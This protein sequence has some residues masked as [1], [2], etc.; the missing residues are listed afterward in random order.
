MIIFH[1]NIS[2]YSSTDKKEGATTQR[3]GYYN[4]ILTFVS[5]MPVLGSF[6][7]KYL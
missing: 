2:F 4:T 6:Q 5:L 1:L 3:A 7:S